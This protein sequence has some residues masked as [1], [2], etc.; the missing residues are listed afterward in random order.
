MRKPNIVSMAFLRSL[1]SAKSTQV[2]VVDVVVVALHVVVLHVVAV[3]VFVVI[4]IIVIELSL[5]TFIS[6]PQCDKGLRVV[7]II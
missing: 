3:V 7:H 1:L 4:V 5:N 6:S 2:P